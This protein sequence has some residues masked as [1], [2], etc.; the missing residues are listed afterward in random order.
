ML[1]IVLGKKEA[2]MD[3]DFWE[4]WSSYCDHPRE[5]I[6]EEDYQEGFEWTCCDGAAEDVG[7]VVSRHQFDPVLPSGQRGTA[8]LD[9]GDHGFLD[10]P[11]VQRVGWY[12]AAQCYMD[13]GVLQPGEGGSQSCAA[14]DQPLEDHHPTKR[15]RTG[16]L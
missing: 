5:M 12:P 15:R 10:L 13:S 14:H 8:G 7:C 2:N 6:D 3:L 11:T 4:D 9:A 16:G 1:L